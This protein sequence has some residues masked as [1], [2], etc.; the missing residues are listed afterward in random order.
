MKFR[1]SLIAVA[2]TIAASSAFAQP[3]PPTAP[4]AADVTNGNG[5]NSSLMLSVWDPIRNVSL[6]QN[7][8]VF[9]NDFLPISTLTPSTGLTLTMLRSCVAR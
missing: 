6:I 7:L 9:L 4:V 8:G 2:L 5:G 1:K 3:T